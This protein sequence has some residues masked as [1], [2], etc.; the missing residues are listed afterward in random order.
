MCENNTEEE[1][2]NNETVYHYCSLDT[3]LRIIKDKLL[4]LSDPLKMNDA[5]ELK[6]FFKIISDDCFKQLANRAGA[7]E[8]NKDDVLKKLQTMVNQYVFIASFSI[9]NDILSQWRAYGDDGKGVSIGFNFNSILNH[10]LDLCRVEYVQE[11]NALDQRFYNG[12]KCAADQTE[13]ML[14]DPVE[15]IKDREKCFIDNFLPDI[16]RFK[17]KSFEEEKEVRLIYNSNPVYLQY[18]SDCDIIKYPS[19]PLKHHFRHRQDTIVEYVVVDITNCIR[20]VTIGPKCPLSEDDVK[21]ICREMY[22]DCI[23]VNKSI[24]SYR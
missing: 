10:T 1:K 4:F 7:P 11:I 9:A 16:L 22:G 23:L 20:E 5:D 19:K 8:I 15:S 21:H 24:S 17:N 18:I 6:Y 2:I 12:I 13:Q 14:D 3:F